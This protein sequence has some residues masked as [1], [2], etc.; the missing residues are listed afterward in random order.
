M[1]FT[2]G[3]Y[4][5]KI[6]DYKNKAFF[7]FIDAENEDYYQANQLFL[8][9]GKE[10]RWIEI[11]LP[12]DKGDKLDNAPMIQDDFEEYNPQPVEENKLDY[13]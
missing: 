2:H 8:I 7:R 6:L 11:K 4:M 10:G 5:N 3:M 9:G 1:R 12:I 13:D